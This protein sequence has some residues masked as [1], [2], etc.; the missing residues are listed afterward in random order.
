MARMAHGGPSGRA[1]RWTG[2]PMRTRSLSRRIAEALSAPELAGEGYQRMLDVAQRVQLV[3]GVVA[4]AAIWVVPDVPA[5]D[6]AVVTG[7]LLC[8]YLPWTLLSNRIVL[9]RTGPVARVVNL[10]IDV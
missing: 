3:V 6:A 9:L 5:G 7:V 2:N 4:L 8:V 10:S 1:P